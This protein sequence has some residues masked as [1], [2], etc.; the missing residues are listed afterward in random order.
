MGER[1]D[2][3]KILTQNTN[4]ESGDNSTVTPE[5]GQLHSVLLENVH[6]A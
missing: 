4:M 2:Q 5:L 3:V 6:M 1:N